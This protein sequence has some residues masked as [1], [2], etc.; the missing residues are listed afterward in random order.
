MKNITNNKKFN[1]NTQICTVVRIYNEE[2]SYSETRYESILSENMPGGIVDAL[3][4]G[5]VLCVNL[6]PNV[7]A[8]YFEKPKDWPENWTEI[9]TH[10]EK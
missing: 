2:G 7:E 10:I 9:G 6:M 5:E 3:V 8:Y 4:S 1:K